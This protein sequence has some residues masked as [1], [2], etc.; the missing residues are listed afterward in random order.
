MRKFGTRLR[1][2]IF[3]VSLIGTWVMVENILQVQK[4]VD[5]NMKGTEKVSERPGYYDILFSGTSMSITNIS[6]EE[7]YLKYG[8]AGIALGEPEQVTY[9]SYYTIENALKYQSPKVVLYDVKA[10]FYTEDRL[11][12][13]IEQNEDYYVHYTLDDMTNSMTKFEAVKQ[14]KE[15]HPES[16]YW[17]YFSKMYHNHS[18]WENISKQNFRT[19]QSS[20]FILEGKNSAGIWEN[21]SDDNHISITD[22]TNEVSEIPEINKKYLEKMAE[23]CKSKNVSL[24]L[25]RNTGSKNWS[26]GEYNA[27][28]EVAKELGLD[29]LDLALYEDEIGFDW[30]TDSFDGTH[31]NIIGTKKW[32]DFLGEYLINKY[33]FVDKRGNEKYDEY[34]LT[35]DKYENVVTAMA[36][37]IILS[38]ATN[39]NQY[40]DTLYNLDKNGNAIF[41]SVSDDASA[42]L[43]QTGQEILKAIGFNT[44]LVGNIQY[45]YY[46]VL[47]D[48]KLVSECC[49]ESGSEWDGN[50]NDGTLYQISSGGLLSGKNASIQINNVQHIQGGRGFNI[51]VYN[52]KSGRVISSVFFDTN[53]E[54]NPITARRNAL[55]RIE[56]EEKINYWISE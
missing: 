8:M 39:F 32:T 34:E 9:L 12:E 51:V 15:L 7:L 53:I 24:V 44:D 14:V 47:D 52:K 27:A 48:G 25:I 35:K 30:R 56:K 2:V 26:W 22:N 38:K 29:Y 19:L 18:N 10:L 42:S 1:V 17:R 41:I 33:D 54:S 6:A 11:K 20:D 43:T 5:W 40:L 28:A 16:N 46:G 37:Q 4:Y 45:S 50:L 3:I 49:N 13:M 55:G 31:H 36:Q 21:V 23:L